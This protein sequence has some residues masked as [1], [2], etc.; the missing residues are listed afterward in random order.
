MRS[1]GRGFGGRRLVRDRYPGT[2]A[3]E[4]ANTRVYR[5][6]DAA[7]LQGISSR[8]YFDLPMC[9]IFQQVRIYERRVMSREPIPTLLTTGSSLV[10]LEGGTMVKGEK[11]MSSFEQKS[12]AK[13]GGLL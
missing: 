4:R 6:E 3:S 1:F 12:T 5:P 10:V 2:R 9:P 7:S 13:N 8:Y 11:G